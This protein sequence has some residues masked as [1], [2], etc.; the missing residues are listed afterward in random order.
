MRKKM[1]FSELLF[2][3]TIQGSGK[4]VSHDCHS[5]KGL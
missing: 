3:E 2:A 4:S 1:E 5:L